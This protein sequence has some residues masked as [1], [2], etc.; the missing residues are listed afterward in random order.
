MYIHTLTSRMSLDHIKNWWETDGN[1]EWRIPYSVTT[2][3]EHKM[4]QWETDLLPSFDDGADTQVL[5][6]RR[7]PWKKHQDE[8]IVVK[9]PSYDG[10]IPRLPRKKIADSPAEPLLSYSDYANLVFDAS[11]IK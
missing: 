9:A 3:D 6:K 2:S 8:V 5:K 1:G 7:H 4:I 11:K 10:T